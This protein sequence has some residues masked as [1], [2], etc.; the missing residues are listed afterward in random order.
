MFA[1]WV[2]ACL[3]VPATASAAGQAPI[4]AAGFRDDIAFIRHTIMRVHPDPGFSV[5][6]AAL[7][8]ALDA[9][10]ADVPPTMT[11]DDAWR[12]LATLNP[13]LADAHLFVGHADWRADTMAHLAAG[14]TL[15]PYEV[16]IGVDGTLSIRA[17]LG[18][19][20]TPLAGTRILAIDGV[21]ATAA[22]A[23]LS[24]LVHGDTPLFRAALLARRW[25]L[26]HWKTCGSPARYRLR[27]Q[28][29]AR[30]WTMDV[31]AA[32]AVPAL[33]RDDGDF[34]RRFRIDIRPG[35]RAVLTVGS[36]DG[37]FR[38]RFLSF[39]RAAFARMRE[40]GVSALTIDVSENGGGDDALWLDGLM[41][42]LAM[43]P[44]R[45]GSTYVKTVLEPDAA[46]GETAG[47]VVHGE[48]GTWRQPDMDNPLRFRG[49][50]SVAIGPSTYSSA[51]LF[52]N[53]MRDFGF[54]TLAGI[55]G[56]ARRTQSGGIRRFVLPHSGLV[57]WVPRFVLAPPAG[58][59]RDALLV[60][61]APAIQQP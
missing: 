18:G 10:A 61:A 48:I 11:R 28:D 5:D 39:T 36:L 24:A 51:V 13:L 29:G 1:R 15:F 21:P 54:G 23:D 19:G 43:R 57:L 46:R 58:A 16:D 6:P 41:P 32:T 3:L 45:T 20:A 25:W 59:A 44:Y 22:V 49:K 12:R 50:V 35:A 53:V 38:E 4:D 34:A 33:L 47:Q 31:A 30:Q 9:L 27:L 26:Y 17:A 56:A 42:Y 55:G 8:R 40:E 14:G 37:A 52:A 7:D 2:L 60:P